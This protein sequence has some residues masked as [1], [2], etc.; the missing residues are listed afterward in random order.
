MSGRAATQALLATSN[1]PTTLHRSPSLDIMVN[2]IST[3]AQLAQISREGFVV[4]RRPGFPG[5]RRLQS[6]I[7][8]TSD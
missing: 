2:E 8:S 4:S 7:F 5:K 3:V 1:R 6:R